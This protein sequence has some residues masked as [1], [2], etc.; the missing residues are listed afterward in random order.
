MS[1]CLRSEYSCWRIEY[2]NLSLNT[3]YCYQSGLVWIVKS[4][5]CDVFF[6]V[7]IGSFPNWLKFYRVIDLKYSFEGWNY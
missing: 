6:S 1:L 7:S 2:C 5:D 3:A 4:T